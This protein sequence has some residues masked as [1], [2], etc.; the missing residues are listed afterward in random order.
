MFSFI[1]SQVAIYF[2]TIQQIYKEPSLFK[3]RFTASSE[4]GSKPLAAK[5]ILPPACVDEAL[6]C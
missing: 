6:L 5:F 2:E 4:T 1:T 3:M